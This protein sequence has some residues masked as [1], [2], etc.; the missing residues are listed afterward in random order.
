MTTYNSI[1]KNSTVYAD[2]LALGTITYLVTDAPAFVLVGS[3][4]DETLILWDSTSYSTTAKNATT[5]TDISK[6]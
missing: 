4:E 2:S 1:N 6:N 3:A 5:F